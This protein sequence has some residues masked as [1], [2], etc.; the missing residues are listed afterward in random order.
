[1]WSLPP[2]TTMYVG[3]FIVTLRTLAKDREGHIVDDCS[4]TEHEIN[5]ECR[6]NMNVAANTRTLSF[7]T[8]SS[9]SD[10]LDTQH[11]QQGLDTRHND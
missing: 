8:T 10:A 2:D 4:A 5:E 3:T 6:K 9:N 7:T 11:T 1:M